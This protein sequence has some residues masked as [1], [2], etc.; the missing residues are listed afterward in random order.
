MNYIFRYR[1]GRYL[2]FYRK[3]RTHILEPTFDNLF[4]SMSFWFFYIVIYK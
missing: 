2:L 3:Q 4:F 1:Y